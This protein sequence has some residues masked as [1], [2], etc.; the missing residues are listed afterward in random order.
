MRREAPRLRGGSNLKA[1]RK[2][3][4]IVFATLFAA[5]QGV[6]RAECIEARA[7]DYATGASCCLKRTVETPVPT[8]RRE[9]DGA[10]RLTIR[11]FYAIMKPTIRKAVEIWKKT[12]R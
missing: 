11:R 8:M 5:K 4:S 7:D 1:K 3:L 12:K 2:R 9:Q 6:C 10:L